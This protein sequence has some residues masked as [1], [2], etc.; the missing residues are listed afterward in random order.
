MGILGGGQATPRDKHIY[1]VP[2]QNGQQVTWTWFYDGNYG[3]ITPAASIP[4]IDLPPASGKHKISFTIANPEGTN[5]KFA[6][7][8]APGQKSD[9]A[10]WLRVKQPGQAKKKGQDLGGQI[11]TPK[12]QKQGY[13]LVFDDNN[14]NPAAITFEY[15]LNFVDANTNLPVTSIDPDLKNGGGGNVSY[16]M[17]PVA[18]LIGGILIGSILV[19]LVG[20]MRHRSR[21]AG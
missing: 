12:I 16:W 2:Q 20:R 8:S 7:Y 15:Q 13:Q 11:D 19:A 10:L 5:I 9:D 14:D 17:E 18:Y 1:L 4:V 3:K 21:H 6:G